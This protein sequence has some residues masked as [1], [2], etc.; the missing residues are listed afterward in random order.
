MG[1]EAW[2]LITLHDSDSVPSAVPHHC[3]LMEDCKS[4]AC[5]PDKPSYI[6]VK[7]AVLQIYSDTIC[8]IIYHKAKMITKRNDSSHLLACESLSG[9]RGTQSCAERTKEHKWFV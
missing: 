6:N 8:Q 2:G 9:T 3:E 5:S 4:A 1:C 7:A